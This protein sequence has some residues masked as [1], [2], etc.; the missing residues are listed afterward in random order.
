MVHEPTHEDLFLGV[1]GFVSAPDTILLSVFIATDQALDSQLPFRDKSHSFAG[2]PQT[3]PHT[4]QPIHVT[5]G[6]FHS[7]IIYY[8]HRK[9]PK[10]QKTHFKRKLQST[11]FRVS[12]KTINTVE[13][14]SKNPPR[15]INTPRSELC[16]TSNEQL[17]E[18]ASYQKIILK[19]QMLLINQPT[20]PFGKHKGSNQDDTS[21]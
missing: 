12:S 18:N 20:Y 2:A 5:P 11:P 6:G 7:G 4:I 19:T 8:I 13:S 21:Y 15:L 9:I 3:P 14:S 10:T 16:R 17:R 1:L